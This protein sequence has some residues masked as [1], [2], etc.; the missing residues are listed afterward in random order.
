MD[1]D[2][3]LVM[4]HG[5]VVQFDTPANLVAQPGPLRSLVD[6]TGPTNA[7]VLIK[8]AQRGPAEANQ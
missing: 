2:R 3:I 1:Y 6:E 7:E 8:L 4:D 5:K